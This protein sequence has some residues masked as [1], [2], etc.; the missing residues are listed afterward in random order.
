MKEG[1]REDHQGRYAYNNF[2]G[3]SRMGDASIVRYVG[4]W[5]GDVKQ[6]ESG[7]G[8]TFFIQLR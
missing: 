7:E 2:E 6:D 4:G 1:L 8:K 5:K 3:G